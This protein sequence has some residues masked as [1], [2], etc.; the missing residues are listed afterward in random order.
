MIERIKH[1]VIKQGIVKRSQIFLAD[2][3]ELFSPHLQIQTKG[4][5]NSVGSALASR[6]EGG[7]IDPWP[8][9]PG[10]FEW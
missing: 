6:A 9:T 5:G 7:E 1:H 10:T 8:R 4:L 3:H 2:A